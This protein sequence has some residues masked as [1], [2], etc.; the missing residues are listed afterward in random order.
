MANCAHCHYPGGPGLGN[1]DARIYRLLSTVNILNGSLINNLGNTANRVIVPGS[2]ANSVMYTRMSS[3]DPAIRMPD[4]GSVVPDQQALA[5]FRQWIDGELQGFQTFAEWQTNYFGGTNVPN[6]NAS[7]DF[8][9]DGAKNFLEYL[10]ESNPT[11]ALDS[12]QGVGIERGTNSVN[13][14]IP[15]IAN[16]GFEVQW[17]TNLQATSLWRFLDVPENVPQYSVSNR[18]HRVPDAVGANPKFY[19]VR[20]YDH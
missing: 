16:R 5:V 17:T 11:N 12:W 7:G 2:L 6:G 20:V 1:Y 8:D 14:V 10:T 13:I 9:G 19:R 4:Q 3:T 18:T 15:Q